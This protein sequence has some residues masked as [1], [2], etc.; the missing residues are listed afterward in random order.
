MNEISSKV[1]DLKNMG[2]D[3]K[4]NR[5]TDFEMPLDEGIKHIVKVLR[6]NGVET[7]ESCEGGEGHAFPEP[8]VLFHGEYAEGFRAF[9]V[10]MQH[11]LP[12]YKLKRVYRVDDSELKGPWWEMTFIP[13]KA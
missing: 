10:V 5:R 4:I 13:T 9:A 7:F 2:T 1:A 8:T 12:I 11:Q 6:E 3:C